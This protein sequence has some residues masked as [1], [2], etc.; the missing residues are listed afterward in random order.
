M[1]RAMRWGCLLVGCVLLRLPGRAD[2]ILPPSEPSPPGSV[3]FHQPVAAALVD[4]GRTLCIAGH[5]SGSLLWLDLASRQVVH[6]VRI[7]QS[8]SD[9]VPH[10][11]GRHL[12]VT[13]EQAHELLVVRSGTAGDVAVVQRQPVA[14]FP[15]SVTCSEDGRHCHVAS[16]WS[17]RVTLFDVHTD[18]QTDG[19]DAFELALCT[20]IR[21]GFAPRLQ[22]LL[23]QPNRLLVTDAFGGQLALIDLDAR[24]LESVRALPV[25]NIRGLAVSPDGAR[26][27][28]SH[29]LLDTT[30]PI[31][32]SSVKSGEL[33]ENF[34]CELPVSALLEP[35]ADLERAGARRELGGI[36]RGAGDP[37]GLA[38]LP[39]GD[40]LVAL[41]GTGELGVLSAAGELTARLMVGVRPLAVAV[42][43]DGAEAY[44]L[45]T[46]S[47]SVTPVDIAERRTGAPIPLGPPLRLTSRDRGERLFFDAHQ[48]LEGWLSCHSCHT[49]G[50]TI[51]LLADTS[52]DNSFGTPKRILSLRGT[53]DNNPWSWNGLFR[54]LHEQV[55]SSF[56]STLQGPGISANEA[57]DVVTYL[58]TLEAP[59]PVDDATWSEAERQQIAAGRQLFTTLGCGECHVPP[60]TYTVDQVFDVGLSDERDQS[61]FNPPSLRGLSQRSG[62]FH[63]R[64]AATLEAVF[65]DWG[66]QL[67]RALTAQEQQQ[68]LQFLRS[69]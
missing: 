47:D 22:A 23:P 67:P 14:R 56:T 37:A 43:L 1:S 34:V 38:V 39:D 17:R 20:E 46:L 68:L 2:E 24:R 15:V 53:R 3:R 30:L 48:S 36:G 8:L 28:L 65:E 31:T 66:H 63:D 61:K 64:R 41:A 11:D 9:V 45:N 26:L 51:G 18:V 29:Q 58:H 57:A 21:L 62:Y 54:E 32:R 42:T 59:P 25:H 10:P 5:R 27:F 13:D 4:D 44:V 50:H 55:S 7:G 12:L 19:G 40:L 49:D 69:L 16:L 60:Q 35:Q 33:M 52:S 6:E